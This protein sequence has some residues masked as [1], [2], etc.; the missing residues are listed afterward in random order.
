MTQAKRPPQRALLLI[1]I[2]SLLAAVTTQAAAQLVFYENADF[3]GRSFTTEQAIGNF[4]KY[5]FNDRASSAVVLREDWEVCENVRYAGRC[6]VLRPGRYPSLVAMGMNNRISSVRAIAANSR[7]D[8]S[9]YAPAPMPVYDNQRRVGEALY[10]A[11]ISSVRA[12]VGTPE[13]RCWTEQVQVEPKRSGPNVPIAIAGALLG[14]ILG[15]QVGGGTGK[16]IAT[17]GGAV[18]GGYVGSNVGRNNGQATTQDVQ[19]CTTTPAANTP[20]YWDVTYNFEGIEH[21]I[22]TAAPPTGPTLT[23]NAQ[24]EPRS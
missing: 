4:S 2:A 23:V 13:Q 1:A 22:Q 18:A 7:L 21:R 8:D 3:A 10:Q 16:D 5:G 6:V 14:G 15:H 19:R 17:V 12:V 9:R 20:S 24:G 11:Q